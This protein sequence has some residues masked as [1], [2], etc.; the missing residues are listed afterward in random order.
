MKKVITFKK[1]MRIVEHA[2]KDLDK[3]DIQYLTN[4]NDILHLQEELIVCIIN[5]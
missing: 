1:L 4:L 5:S 2:I 3:N